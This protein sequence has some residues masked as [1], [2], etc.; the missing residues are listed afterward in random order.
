MTLAVTHAFTSAIADAGD[1]TLV[2][3]SNW[4]AAHTLTGV[5]SVAQG[6][7][8]A[9][10]AS[11]TSLDNI[12][13][14][15]STGYIKRTGAGT[16]T[17]A[18]PIAVVDGG[19]GL[20]S[21]TSGGVLA[22]TA[23]GTLASSAALTANALVLGGG[24]GAA[25]T[26][27]G[28]LGTTTTVLHGNAAGAP[29]F[30]AV[31]L[32]ADVTGNLP[33]ANLNSGT[34]ASS[35]TFW[36]GDG[37]WST[38]TAAAGGANTQVQF[39]SSNALSGDS[40]FT[41]AGSGQ[42]TLA[43]GTITTNLTAL[44]ITGTWNAAGVTFDAPLFM[45]ITNTASAAGS[46]LADFQVSSSS[47]LTI[48]K[49]GV[50]YAGPGAYGASTLA[51]NLTGPG[52]GVNTGIYH[53]NAA[54]GGRINFPVNGAVFFSIGSLGT[55]AQLGVGVPNNAVVGF[56][57]TTGSNGVTDTS[58][59]RDAAVGVLALGDQNLG[60]TAT[61]FRVYNTTDNVGTN[62]A[63]T[64]YERGVI[65]WKTTSN[66]LTIGTQKGG[67]GS[68]RAVNFVGLDF[69]FGTAALNTT[70]T[71]GFIYI[72][73]CAGTP[74]GTPTAYTGTVAMVYDTT[75]NK[76]YIYNGAWKGGTNPGVFT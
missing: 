9:S 20:A 70:A 69:V 65:D 48:G 11:G 53:D 29:T 34:S 50:I 7:T 25:P 28:S 18:S 4:N 39:N 62:T 22:F 43:L 23:A 61:G 30:G 42:V 15:A 58:L 31:S 59:F 72:P 14:F 27:L 16:Y 32:S 51:V 36:R 55:S 71:D 21:G 1:A 52:S 5:V 76:F 2:Q 44:N 8:N 12:T 35:S 66:T 17:F 46:L 37:T 56:T 41:Y 6:G 64:N 24:A 26:A 13:G 19:T 3:P 10:S 57:S 45:N 40:G 47:V 67:T 33:V 49:S 74:T 38:P 60:T 63:P 75:N 54:Q 68:S 73:T